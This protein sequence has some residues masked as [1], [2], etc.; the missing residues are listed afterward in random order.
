MINEDEKQG[1]T[2]NQKWIKSYSASLNKLS[3]LNLN[4]TELRIILYLASI[5]NDR[6]YLISLSQYQISDDLKIKQPNISIAFKSLKEKGILMQ[7]GRKRHLMLNSE[8]F[9][10][11]NNI[12]PEAVNL[13]WGGATI[14]QVKTPVKKSLVAAEMKK[15]LV[16]IFA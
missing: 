8:I 16:D 12:N 5:L 4:L 15:E 1:S 7:K 14:K 10:F 9:Q 11:G 2:Q 6:N 3:K 13:N